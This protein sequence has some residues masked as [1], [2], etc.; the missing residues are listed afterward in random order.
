MTPEH[1]VTVE[2]INKAYQNLVIDKGALE[3]LLNI[4]EA[5]EANVTP[6]MASYD[7][8]PNDPYHQLM[9]VF[10]DGA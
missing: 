1:L 4:R 10:R 9:K 6:K 2:E 8:D 3:N 7:L 5:A